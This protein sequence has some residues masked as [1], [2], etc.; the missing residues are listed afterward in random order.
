MRYCIYLSSESPVYLPIH[1]N[2]ILRGFLFNLIPQAEK[3]HFTYSNFF[4]K[5]RIN[6]ERKRISFLSS[7]HFYV[8]IFE[9]VEVEFPV[10]TELRLGK[11]TVRIDKVD[12]V[13]VT[14]NEKSIKVK[15]LSPVTVFQSL[16]NGKTLYH[17]PTNGEFFKKLEEDLKE[18]TEKLTGIRPE[19]SVQPS[20][21]GVFKKAVVQYRNRFVIEAWKGMFD[22]EGDPEALRV[23][24]TVGLG[25]RNSQGF[26]MVATAV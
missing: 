2:H 4:G 3:L 24:L 26:G 17:R 11:N 16:P 18:K 12:A 13:P 25:G 9:D 14:V 10:G 15:T 22:L 6:K 21:E 23:A 19:I 5:K 8:S 1:Y 20:P 7:F